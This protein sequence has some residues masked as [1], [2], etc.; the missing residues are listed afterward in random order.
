VKWT[1]GAA[2]ATTL[3]GCAASL[4]AVL[5]L[6][7]WDLAA[8]TSGANVYFEGHKVDAR[9]L[10]IREDVQ[11][12]VTTVTEAEGVK[13][14]YTNGKFQGNTG[15]EMNAQRLFAHYPSLFVERF[16][17]ALV[18][19]LGT[20]TTLGTLTAY[21]WRSIDVAEIS[22][23]IVEAGGATSKCRTAGRSGIR[24][25]GSRS[26]MAAISCWFGR[27]VTT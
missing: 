21:P 17:A 11:G 12:G 7:R 25:F 19:G 14:L 24:A 16:D 15:W 20:A 2:R 1:S 5:L 23:A 6:P 18:I 9:L 3:A 10:S 22:P 27:S 8:L 13:T 4:L 26:R